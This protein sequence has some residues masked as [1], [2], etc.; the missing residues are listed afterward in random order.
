MNKVNPKLFIYITKVIVNKNFKIKKKKKK[1]KKKIRFR[2]V[3][4]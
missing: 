3:K 2:S 1:K 4:N